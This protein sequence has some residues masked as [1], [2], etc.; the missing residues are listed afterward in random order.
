MYLKVNLVMGTQL[1]LSDHRRGLS[2][3]FFHNRLLQFQN[4]TL[5]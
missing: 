4:P 3:L 2:D 1:L 5:N